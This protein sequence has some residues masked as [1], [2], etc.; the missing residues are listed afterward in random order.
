MTYRDGTPI[1]QVTDST[2]WTTTYTNAWCYIDNDSS[3]G[4]LYKWRAVAGIHDAASFTDISKRKEFAPNGWRVPNFND[5]ETLKNYL[6]AN[7]Y[8]YDGT[9]TGNKIAKAM[10]ST[11]GWVSSSSVGN[12]QSLNNKSGFN[13]IPVGTRH[14]LKVDGGGQTSFNHKGTD[15]VFWSL[16]AKGE[17]GPANR[18]T[19]HYRNSDLRYGSDVW[20]YGFS[21]RFVRDA[22]T[23]STKDY[24]N[25]ITIYPNPTTSIVTLQLS[26]IHISEPTRPY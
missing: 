11:T 19:L 10:A 5:W 22:S 2:E 14:N 18:R 17:S 20:D 1:P 13:A 4:K 9:T 3:K 8:N 26:L 23:A 6:I 16:S 25:A 21:V 7:G 15:V 24:S 12:D